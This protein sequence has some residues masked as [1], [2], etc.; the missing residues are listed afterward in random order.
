MLLPVYQ[1]RRLGMGVSTVDRERAA[2]RLGR[3]A[4]TCQNSLD[5]LLEGFGYPP[6]NFSVRLERFLSE[7]AVVFQ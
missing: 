7:K 1:G 6:S 4:L 5:R 2:E 3:M